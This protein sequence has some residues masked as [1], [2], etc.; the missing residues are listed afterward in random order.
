MPDFSERIESALSGWK[1]KLR[2]EPDAPRAGSDPRAAGIAELQ[3][4][5]HDLDT[6]LAN[7]VKQSAVEA[8]RAS[9]LETR[10]MEA[11][12]AGDDVLARECLRRHGEF[13]GTAQKLEADALVLRAMIA[14]CREV[15]EQAGT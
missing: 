1:A 15:L 2:P 13:L 7:A 9:E 4:A 10:A 14:E 12:R 11:I 5:M 3:R 8:S 6:D